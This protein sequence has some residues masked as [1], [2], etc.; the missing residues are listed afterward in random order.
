M[1]EN[2]IV[3]GMKSLYSYCAAA[4]LISGSSSNPLYQQ[5]CGELS[6]TLWIHNDHANKW[7]TEQTWHTY[8]MRINNSPTA[9][10]ANETSF[11]TIYRKQDTTIQYIEN[12]E[13][14]YFFSI[15]TAS[16]Q[17][18]VYCGHPTKM[19]YSLLSDTDSDPDSQL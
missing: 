16:K 3:P 19:T 12:H 13:F 14:G 15:G 10:L 5:P 11:L 6:Q 1:T 4:K 8:Y 17:S 2:A 18:H 7:G 9:A